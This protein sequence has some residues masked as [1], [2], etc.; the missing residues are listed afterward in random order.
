ML[1]SRKLEFE[2]EEKMPN[3]KCFQVP[4]EQFSKESQRNY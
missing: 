3:D 4:V 1:L 2:N